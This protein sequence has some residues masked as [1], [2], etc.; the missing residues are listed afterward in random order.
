MSIKIIIDQKSLE[1]FMTIKK[2]TRHQSYK[3]DFLSCFNFVIFISLV[4]IIEK[5]I[6]ER[7]AQIIS[8]HVTIMTV[9]NIRYSDFFQKI[10]LSKKKNIIIIKKVIKWNLEDDY[11]FKLLYLFKSRI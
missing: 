9:N 3:A 11:D 7:V 5:N 10:N 1:K 6:N 8:H 2:L 4:K